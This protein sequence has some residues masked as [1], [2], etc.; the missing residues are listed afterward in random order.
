MYNITNY[1]YM[2]MSYMLLNYHYI[3]HL[4]GH[5]IGLR[6]KTEL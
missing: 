5:T 4:H 3:A 2:S 6:G 1:N